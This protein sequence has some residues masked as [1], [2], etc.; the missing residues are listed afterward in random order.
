MTRHNPVVRFQHMLDQAILSLPMS[1]RTHSS[2]C[3]RRGP[4]DRCQLDAA[5][6]SRIRYEDHLI[7]VFSFL[8]L[9]IHK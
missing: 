9:E 3:P 8:G 2:R 7:S 4:P 6:M 5:E 1:I